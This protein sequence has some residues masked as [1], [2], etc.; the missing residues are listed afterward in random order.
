M[1]A[2][3]CVH[4]RDK[5]IVYKRCVDIFQLVIVVGPGVTMLFMN[6]TNAVQRLPGVS[7]HYSRKNTK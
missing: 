2:H 1:R 7:K 3:A 5:Q 4:V 6:I